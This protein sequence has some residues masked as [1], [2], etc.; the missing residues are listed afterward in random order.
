MGT[1]KQQGNI[2]SCGSD[3]SKRGIRLIKKCRLLS[4]DIIWQVKW[5]Y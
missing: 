2:T 1:H 4:Y 5:F 3:V